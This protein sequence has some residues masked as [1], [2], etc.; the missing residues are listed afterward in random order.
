ML[1][2]LLTAHLFP[3]RSSFI[4]VLTVETCLDEQNNLYDGR[5]THAVF[6][7]RL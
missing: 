2:L 7:N 6:G 1:T 5:A 3:F 4:L